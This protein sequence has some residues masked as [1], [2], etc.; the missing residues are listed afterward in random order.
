M[1]S[2]LESV[3]SSTSQ[4]ELFTNLRELVVAAQTFDVFMYQMVYV[5][6][7]VYMYMYVYVHL[8]ELVVAA[9]TFD[10]Y[11]YQMVYVYKY[12]R[13]CVYIYHVYVRAYCV[14]MC[15]CMWV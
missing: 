6:A 9:Q 13:V 1:L 12:R 11:M 14:Y 3:N 10:V 7:C 15:M 8:R 4:G 5:C 2:Y